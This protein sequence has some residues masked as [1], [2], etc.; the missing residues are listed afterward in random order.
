[1][2]ANWR[3]LTGG[4]RVRDDAR[5]TLLA[6]SGGADSTALAILMAAAAGEHAAAALGL[7]HIQHDLRSTDQTG[8]DEEQTRQLAERLGLRFFRA[9]VAVKDLPGNIESAARRARYRALAAIARQNGFRFIATGHHAD[10]QLESVLMAVVRGAG[11]S[12]LRGVHESRV[13]GRVTIIRPMLGLTRAQCRDVCVKAVV[14]WREDHTNQDQRLLR[15]ALRA[16]VVPSI[17][18]IRPGAATK[19]A[20]MAGLMADLSGLVRDRARALLGDALPTADPQDRTASLLWPRDRLRRER[21]VVLGELI[22]T[23]SG[24]VNGPR[25]KDSLSAATL[26]QTAR[27]IRDQNRTPREREIGPIV[28]RVTAREFLVSR[29]AAAKTGQ[30]AE[31]PGTPRGVS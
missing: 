30:G 8:A 22:R 19:A 6:C 9:D 28:V 20:T 7:A 25:G 29:R 17:S 27:M 24:I 16:R 5:P 15:A 26:L 10:D 21:E 12:G 13:M 2:A 11:P 18:D 4:A 3:R 31:E 23:A 14:E 1:V